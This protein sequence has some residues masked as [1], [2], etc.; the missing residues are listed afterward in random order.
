[1]QI[2]NANLNGLDK[3]A[4]AQNKAIS[5]YLD[6]YIDLKIPPGFAV[7]L[8]GKWGSGKSWFIKD[9]LK[10]KFG[11]DNE[12]GKHYLYVS[13]YGMTSFA[14]IEREFFRQLH[15]LL[16]SKSV[17]FASKL[18]SGLL[19]VSL[20][21]DAD[22][23]GNPDGS[24]GTKM[25]ASS[26]FSKT[27]SVT[28]RPI[29][30]D[31]VERC[32]IPLPVLL[33]YLNQLVEQSH[34]HVIL[35]ANEDELLKPLKA[36]EESVV[37]GKDQEAGTR[38]NAPEYQRI[39]EKLIGQSFKVMPMV[40]QAFESFCAELPD[41]LGK[42]VV[43]DNAGEIKEIYFASELENLRLLRCALMEFCRFAVNLDKELLENKELAQEFIAEYVCY[44]ILLRSGEF[45]GNELGLFGIRGRFERSAGIKNT[46]KEK[47]DL[48]RD[49]FRWISHF[50]PL[51]DSS[52]WQAVLTGGPWP[53]DSIHQAL[54]NSRHFASKTT[55]NWIQLWHGFYMLS[56]QE[57]SQLL[58]VVIREWDSKHYKHE[59]EVLHVFGMLLE[60][61]RARMHDRSATKLVKEVKDYIRN[62]KERGYLSASEDQG[63]SWLT[64]DSYAQL[65]FQGL[66][67][68]EFKEI[69]NFLEM[70]KKQTAKE[71]LPGK[72]A[73]LLEQLQAGGD[74]DVFYR[75]LAVGSHGA[76]IHSGKP[77]LTLIKPEDFMHAVGH[78]Y[79]K[80]L[81]NVANTFRDRYQGNSRISALVSEQRWLGKVKVLLQKLAK[82]RQGKNSARSI[83]SVLLPRIDQ[84][85]ES[86]NS[87]VAP[88]ITAKQ[89]TTKPS[90]RAAK[91]AA[92]KRTSRRE[93][94]KRN[95]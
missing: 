92:K 52:L 33:G 63:S 21:F 57:F 45:H 74:S 55:P 43:E 31:D 91:P 53:I 22:G 83:N 26:F 70:Q 59:G 78:L 35:V 17:K 81:I 49:K 79:G 76:G 29:I 77:I 7:L 9:F 88:R 84:A 65:Q 15:P 23:D 71:A 10:R 24:V 4:I 50:S 82:D 3:A 85:I 20:N 28:D 61:K 62:L 16:S 58:N 47:A 40:E 8:S 60:C 34:M 73:T 30:F 12:G 86:L 90:P 46:K 32:S 68:P 25:P 54:R 87:A 19:R 93:I 75:E 6:Y 94:T 69:Q 39:K 18:V 37:A 64:R 14:D 51:L 67:S 36:P 72:A 66:N 13:L 27:E 56:D 42:Q 5:D 44:S 89:L 2:T 11:Q 38:A 95:A 41:G 80:D 1:M 48:W